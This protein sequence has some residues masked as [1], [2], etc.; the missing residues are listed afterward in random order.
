M[1]QGFK[2]F[3]IPTGMSLNEEVAAKYTRSWVRVGQGVTALDLPDG[4]HAVVGFYIAPPTTGTTALRLEAVDAK[5]GNAVEL[6][7]LGQ[8]PAGTVACP[9][10][11]PIPITYRSEAG[12]Q[13][14]VEATQ[15]AYIVVY[16]FRCVP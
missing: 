1:A 6:I 13:I 4:T 10:T 2:Y 5:T 16:G 11:L 7:E 3:M 8:Q 14:R 15:T 12:I 9:C